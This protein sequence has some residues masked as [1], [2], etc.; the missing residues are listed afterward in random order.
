MIL[1]HDPEQADLNQLSSLNKLDIIWFTHVRCY[2][3]L[4]INKLLI[5]DPHIPQKC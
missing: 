3:V 5:I 2:W 4:I 1:P